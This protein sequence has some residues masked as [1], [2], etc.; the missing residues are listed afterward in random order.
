MVTNVPVE[1]ATKMA[2]VIWSQNSG[3][4]MNVAKTLIFGAEVQ[5]GWYLKITSIINK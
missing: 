4:Y 5:V 3:F 1:E 2:Q